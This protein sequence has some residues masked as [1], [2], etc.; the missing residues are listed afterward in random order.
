MQRANGSLKISFSK[1][2]ISNLHYT[3]PLRAFSNDDGND[4]IPAAVIVN[5]SGGLVSGDKHKVNINLKNNCKALIFS[6]SAEKIY[7]S[8]NNIEANISNEIKVGENSWLEW[9][10]QETILFENSRLNRSL[11]IYLSKSS[12]SLAG[13]IVVLGRLAKG[14]FANNVFLKDFISVYKNSKMQWLDIVLFDDEI[15]KARKSITRLGG[16]NCFFTIVFSSENVEKYEQII[17]KFIKN[18]ILDLTISLT[19]INDNLVIRGMSEDPLFLR[20]IFAK[21]WIFI[22]SDIKKL[23]PFMPKLWWV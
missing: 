8:V 17:Y 4:D 21:I 2:E 11:K 16:A 9:L 1:N 10:P 5:T 13:E 3:T 14:E 23:P 20:K 18:N 15:K 6:Q 19:I 7:K 22:R 12:E